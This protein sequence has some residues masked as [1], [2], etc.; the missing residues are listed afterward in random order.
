MGLGNNRAIKYIN[1][2]SFGG[3][4]G[5]LVSAA[6]ISGTSVVVN[7]PGGTNFGVQ[8]AAIGMTVYFLDGQGEAPKL[9]SAAVNTS[10]QT[11]LTIPALTAN[12]AIGAK[13]FIDQAPNT[14]LLV[15]GFK[16]VRNPKNWSPT[17]YTQTRAARVA[18]VPG[19]RETTG[20][21]DFLVRPTVNAA[22]LA[23]A[24]GQDNVFGTVSGSPLSTTTAGSNPAGATVLN[25]TLGT[26]WGAG[27]FVQIEANGN[28]KV[29]VHKVL[30]VASNVITL[31]TGESL[32]YSHNAGVTAFRVIAPFT[33]TIPAANSFLSS[34]AIEDYVPYDD[35]TQANGLTANSYFMTGV[36]F[37]K[38][39][40]E[41][42]TTDGIT[43][44][45]DYICQSREL[46]VA[47]AFLATPTENP[48]FFQQE[49]V[50]VSGTTNNRIST[51]KVDIKN[52]VQVSYTK[53]GQA[54]PF[55][56]KAGLQDVA[57]EFAFLEDAVTQLSFWN[58]F[59]ANTPFTLSWTTTDASTGNFVTWA[60]TKV[61][62]DGVTDGDFKP[63][64]LVY[65]KIPFTAFLD[66]STTVQITLTVGNGQWLPF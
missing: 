10:T 57:G 60:M 33:H 42:K 64:E 32:Q 24:I 22:L 44:S 49:A 5:A 51:M 19:R 14:M 31:Q 50:L 13:V 7:N 8:A 61:C 29:E 18:W 65:A 21:I 59:V 2:P 39:T 53:S 6:S 3:I 12:H 66:T 45:L 17:P 20:S 41:G 56:I 62:L 54:F 40:L 38:I 27:D 23:K 9:V 15:D 26:G 35:V 25:V 63:G 28:A 58:N 1:E 48:L 55:A 46:N 52:N 43:A 11:T 47:S 36:V 30:S 4:Y 34:I 16:A 37:D